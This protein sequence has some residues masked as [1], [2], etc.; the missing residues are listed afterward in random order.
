MQDEETAVG[1]ADGALGPHLDRLRRAMQKLRANGDRSPTGIVVP[2][3][4]PKECLGIVLWE[5]P[6]VAG[7]VDKPELDFHASQ[8]Q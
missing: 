8:A 5:L 2:R 7:D 4:F 3:R 1:R 6:V